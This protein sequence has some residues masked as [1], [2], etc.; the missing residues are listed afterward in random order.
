MGG[1]DSRFDG[2]VHVIRPEQAIV[3]QPEVLSADQW[4]S[5]MENNLGRTE[6]GWLSS[7][8]SKSQPAPIL[9]EPAEKLL[10]YILSTAPT[11]DR[12]LSFSNFRPDP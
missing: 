7:L 12:C 8:F 6:S 3:M 10:L 11:W 5:F 2:V 1:R 4:E 9:S